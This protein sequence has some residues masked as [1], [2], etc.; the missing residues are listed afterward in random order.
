MLSLF[1]DHI[2]RVSAYTAQALAHAR[3]HQSEFAGIVS[4]PFASGSRTIERRSLVA[5]CNRRRF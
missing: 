4:L 1:Q 5:K 3:E 2:T